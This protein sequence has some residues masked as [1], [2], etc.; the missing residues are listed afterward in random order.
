MKKIRFKRQSLTCLIIAV[1]FITGCASTSGKFATLRPDN[2]VKQS[3][4]TFN[5]DQEYTFYYYGPITFPRAFVGISKQ[6][7]LESDLWKPINLTEQDLRRWIWG[8][9]H[10]V[11]GNLDRFGSNIVGPDGEH[12]GVW[13]S[14]EDW[15]QW[16]RIEVHD[17]NRLTIGSPIYQRQN[18]KRFRSG[19]NGR[20]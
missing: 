10:R 19:G 15:Q 16:A 1:I 2:D 6:M 3:F 4:E 5:A 17:Q 18:G 8:H 9:G 13:Y 12:L 11:Q 14:L 7:T 20:S